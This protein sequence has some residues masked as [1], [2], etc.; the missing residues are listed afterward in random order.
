MAK[1]DGLAW[2]KVFIRNRNL[3]MRCPD[4]A[5]AAAMR[6]LFRLAEDPGYNGEDLSPTAA[7]VFTA[8]RN[9]VEERREEYEASLLRAR[10][11]AGIRWA[12]AQKSLP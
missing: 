12:G 7:L 1:K 9:G 6:G 5:L 10:K 3:V 4:A 8:L 11:A 2:F